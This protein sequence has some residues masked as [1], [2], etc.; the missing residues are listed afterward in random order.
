MTWKERR[1]IPPSTFGTP[2]LRGA[3]APIG[4]SCDTHR[5][6]IPESPDG[7]RSVTPRMVVADVTG[8]VNFLRAV[9]GAT[10][11]LHAGRPAEMRVGDSLVMVSEA[12]ERERFPAF[13]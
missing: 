7:Y 6:T 2:G 4:K 12:G 13:L 8:E 10:G 1:C 5:V 3:S 9:L 11:E